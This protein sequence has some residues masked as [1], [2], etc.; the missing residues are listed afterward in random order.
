MYNKRPQ[1]KAVHRLLDGMCGNARFVVM[2]SSPYMNI[3]HTAKYVE[4]EQAVK[5]LEIPT[6]SSVAHKALHAAALRLCAAA[7]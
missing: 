4:H 6:G 7:D 1:R 2:L 3:L 5:T